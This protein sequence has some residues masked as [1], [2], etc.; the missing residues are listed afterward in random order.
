MEAGLNRRQK[1]ELFEQ[2]RREYEHGVGTI[3]GVARKFGVHRRMVREA[4]ANAVPS[5]RK[6]APRERP[7]LGPAAAWIDG[8]LQ[9]DRKAPRKQRH[10]AH[11]IWVRLRQEMPAVGLAESTVRQYVRKRKRELGLASGETFI[12]QSYHWGQEAQV[13]WYEA[14][15]ELGGERQKLYVFC[16]VDGQWRVV[17]SGVSACQPAGVPGGA[18]DGFP[19]FWGCF[20]IAAIR[21]SE[22][23]GAEDS[24]RT[25]AGRD[26]TVHCLPIALRIPERVLHPKAV[27]KRRA[28]IS[29]GITWCRCR[30]PAIWNTSTSCCWHRAKKRNSA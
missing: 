19:A 8:I 14:W 24:A 1:V 16:M 7:K 26:A 13:D 25:S 28:G 11:R 20:R 2:I 27:W 21:Q 5:P 12:P 29:A 17:S 3:K 23:C 4:V 6:S 30:R 22:K 15:A 9:T 10:T 18:R